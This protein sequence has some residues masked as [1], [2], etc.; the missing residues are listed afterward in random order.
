MKVLLMNDNL[1]FSHLLKTSIC[2]SNPHIEVSIIN[3]KSSIFKNNN[4]IENDLIIIDTEFNCNDSESIFQIIERIRKLND[5]NV[6][7]ML[8]YTKNKPYYQL[9]ANEHGVD[10]YL[11]KDIT[12]EHF[13]EQLDVILNSNEKT[14]SHIISYCKENDFLERLSKRE[15]EVL[16]LIK[17]GYTT[18]EIADFLFISNRTVSNHI[19]IIFGKL[20]VKNRRQAI[21]KACEYGYINL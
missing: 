12:Q 8:L 11:C 9:K 17:E 2:K 15:L 3:K 1:L 13:Q 10:M 18:K 14:N 16:E 21:K 5:G 19:Y 6:K 7:I 20:G 4:L